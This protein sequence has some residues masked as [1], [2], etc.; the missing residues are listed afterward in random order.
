ME[1]GREVCQPRHPRC[2]ICPA[3]RLCEARLHDE[4]DL[5]P[6]RTAKKR[7]PRYVVAVGVIYREGRILIDKRKP[8]GLLGGLWEFPGGKK[9]PD[10]SLQA[11]VRREVREELAITIRVGRLLAV[12][13]HTYSHFR[14]RI[15][16]F[17]CQHVSGEPRCITCAD[18]R[19]VRPVDL[20]RYAFPAANHRIIAALQSR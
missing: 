8:E 12:V 2:A 5:L 3:N 9:R 6:I 17:E 19:W 14:V 16:V 11:A 15:H 7:L 4:Q 13:D 18:F 20:G 10:E 1:L